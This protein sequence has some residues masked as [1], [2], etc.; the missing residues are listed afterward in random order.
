MKKQGGKFKCRE[1]KEANLKKKSHKLY[2]SNHMTF[3]KREN[4]EDTKKI[5]SFQGWGMGMGWI[6]GSQRIFRVVKILYDYTTMDK[7]IVQHKEW[8]LM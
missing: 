4:S 7:Y 5:S 8:T 1:V 3:W 6:G 2:D